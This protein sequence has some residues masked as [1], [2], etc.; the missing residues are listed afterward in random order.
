MQDK[1]EKVKEAITTT[2]QEVIGLKKR[3]QKEWVSAET[4]CKIEERRQKKAEINNCRTRATKAKAQ[5]EYTD[6]N[7]ETFNLWRQIRSS[8]VESP[9]SWKLKRPGYRLDNEDHNGTEEKR[10]PVD[11]HNS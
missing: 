5:Q 8:T 1:W 4:L 6:I 10:D 2:C 11:T 9:R 7:R 3:Q